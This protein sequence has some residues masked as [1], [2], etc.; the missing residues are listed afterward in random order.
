MR[1]R[2]F[3]TNSYMI[4]AALTMLAGCCSNKESVKTATNVDRIVVDKTKHTISLYK[5]KEELETY[6]IGLGKSPVGHKE[7]EG[8]NRTP[9]GTYKII[10][11][12]PKSQYHKALTISYPND[13]DRKKAAKKGVHPGGDIQIHGFRE[14]LAWVR[15]NHD[16]ADVTRGCI[17][18]T[19]PELEKLYA[20]TD[21]GTTIEIRP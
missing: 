21:V 12:N 7:Q 19:N 6:K 11:K 10:H 2:F 1:D 3:N 16:I 14:D 18:L 20:M 9:E 17:L 13:Q 4:L 5:D 8:D 15:Q